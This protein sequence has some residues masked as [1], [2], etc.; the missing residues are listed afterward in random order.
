MYRLRNRMIPDASAMIPVSISVNCVL[1]RAQV[2]QKGPPRQL[3]ARTERA[4]TV[5]ASRGGGGVRPH[6][7]KPW[8]VAVQKEANAGGDVGPLSTMRTAM[9]PSWLT[10][11]CHSQL[12][13]AIRVQD[14]M[15]HRNT[16]FFCRFP[17]RCSIKKF[18]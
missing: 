11:T 3:S 14:V 15:S 10:L 9:T 6:H 4:A 17:L 2:A 13:K 5:G 7:L 1:L 8:V 12:L 18:E 16:S